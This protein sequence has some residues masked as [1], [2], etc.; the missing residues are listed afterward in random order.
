MANMISEEP[1]SVL[2]R[3]ADELRDEPPE[4][5]WV[6]ISSSIISKVRGTARRT[7]P[8]DARYPDTAADGDTLRVSDHV[9]RTTL[10][11][12]L[13]GIGGA[14]PTDISLHVDEHRC[15]GVSIT[16]TG[17]YG[18]D[19]QAVGEVLAYKAIDV[20][21]DILGVGLA[22]ADVDVRVDDIELSL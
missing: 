17:V 16:V 4:P 1:D 11:R 2:A 13:A 6:D 9:V 5:R 18:E 21:D 10:R 8:I 7:W 12:A 3:A 15:T 14:Q 22:R 20:V 19:L